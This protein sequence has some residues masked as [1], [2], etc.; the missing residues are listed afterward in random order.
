MKRLT[1]VLFLLTL[2]G[3]GIQAADIDEN[4]LE[5]LKIDSQRLRSL[6]PKM[7]DSTDPD[8]V[9]EA[10]LIIHRDQMRKRQPSEE[11]LSKV[12]AA[13]QRL[14]KKPEF[15]EGLTRR[16]ACQVLGNARSRK[17]V[18]VLLQALADP[19]LYEEWS[20]APGGAG[21]HVEWFAVW[22]DADRAL[23]RITGANPIPQPRQRDPDYTGKQQKEIR[24]A[25]L[26]W[27]KR[28]ADEAGEADRE[29]KGEAP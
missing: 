28:N 18:P 1:A 16:V 10:V 6:L 27:W 5:Q 25:W 12:N 13:L 3:T 7:L 15:T 23:R 29:K 8:M 24:D 17:D 11:L 4:E 21:T 19:Y 22:R 14:L 2:L 9:G 20:P 26:L